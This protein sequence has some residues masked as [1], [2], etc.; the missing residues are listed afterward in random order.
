M[1][2]IAFA[3][4]HPEMM[5]IAV[6]SLVGVC[7]YLFKKNEHKSAQLIATHLKELSDSIK[8]LARRDEKKEKWMTTMQSQLDSRDAR[9]EERHN[10][11]GRR[12]YDPETRG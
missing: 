3:A 8:D 11:G 12:A 9:C 7:V 2:V 1:T 5:T 10:P 6:T 4:Q